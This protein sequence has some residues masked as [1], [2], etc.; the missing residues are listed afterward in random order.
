MWIFLSIATL[1]V[2]HTAPLHCQTPVLS[3]AIGSCAQITI[4]DLGTTD[5]L[6]AQGLVV[7]AL[8]TLNQ[9][10]VRILR[11]ERVCEASG[12]LRNTST[13]ISVVV[14]YGCMGCQDMGAPNN[15]VIMVTEQ[16]QFVCDQDFFEGGGSSSTYD[17]GRFAPGI[18]RTPSPTAMLTTGLEDQCG[19]CADPA[20]DPLAEQDTH[21][22]SEW[23]SQSRGGGALHHG[24]GV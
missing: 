5:S 9:P 19:L 15:T 16:F 11:F 21:C 4:D 22:R 24:G 14:E 20:F 8:F 10:M 17:S 18:L 3:D 1:L 2:F 12:L 13:S 7:D 23:E 6:S